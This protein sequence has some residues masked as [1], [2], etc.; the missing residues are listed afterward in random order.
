MDIF[1]IIAQWVKHLFH[2]HHEGQPVPLPPAAGEPPVTVPP[3]SAPDHY[4]SIDADGTI[5]PAA[6]AGTPLG[7]YRCILQD[8]YAQP[9]LSEAIKANLS[10]NFDDNFGIRMIDNSDDPLY[11]GGITQGHNY[12]VPSLPASNNAPEYPDVLVFPSRNTASGWP[13][14]RLADCAALVAR[15]TQTG[16]WPRIDHTDRGIVAHG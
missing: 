15:C 12:L 13:G 11:L 1:S 5:K 4:P 8:T 7:N 6:F 2:L 14:F 3:G 10:R 16:K 9:G